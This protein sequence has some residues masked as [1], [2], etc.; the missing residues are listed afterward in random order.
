[1]TH[2]FGGVLDRN[3]SMGSLASL[4]LVATPACLPGEG[5]T[6]DYLDDR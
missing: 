1:M 6:R 3:L 4:E 5:G 2:I